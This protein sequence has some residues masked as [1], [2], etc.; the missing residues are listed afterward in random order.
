MAGGEV[1]D[2]LAQPG[3]GFGLL[4]IGQGAQGVVVARGGDAADGDVA[5]FLAGDRALVFRPGR[6]AAGPGQQAGKGAGAAGDDGRGGQ[7]VVGGVVA[8]AGAGAEILAR[9][10][11]V[12]RVTGGEADGAGDAVRAVEG[13]GRAAQDLDRLHQVEVG[14]AAAADALGPEDEA[15]RR[16]DA[17]DDHQD[18]VAAD[19]ADSE[20][21]IAGAS[22]RAEGGPEASR[23]ADDADARLEADQVLDVGGQ[24]G[25][26]VAVAEDGDR[27]RGLVGSGFGAG[28]QDSDGG[29]FLRFVRARLAGEG[30]PDGGGKGGEP[31][32][33][34]KESAHVNG[35]AGKEPG[36]YCE[37]LSESTATKAGL[38]LTAI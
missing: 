34:E 25:L 36:N 15:V 6:V 37:R 26:D 27:G 20:T 1:P 29:Q 13:R 32:G 3:V 30:G 8:D 4:R 28:G 5:D 18:A 10:D 24:H 38:F 21:L 22:R 35:P 17:V 2:Q 16:A 19:A 12:G 23:L 31:G 14:I 9:P 7:A 11:Q 33:D